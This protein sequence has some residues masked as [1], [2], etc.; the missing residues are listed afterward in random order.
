MFAIRTKIL[1]AM[2]VVAAGTSV[3]AA[4]AASAQAGPPAQFS[5]NYHFADGRLGYSLVSRG[6]PINPGVLVGFN[7]QPDPPGD[8][9]HGALIALL[10]PSS[11]LLFDPN[12]AAS[13]SWSISLVGMADG[14]VMPL[15]VA[16]ENG[17]NT[18]VENMIDGHDVVISLGFGP[19]PIDPTSWASFNPQPDPPGDFLG[20]MFSFATPG[21]PW[22]FFDVFVDGQQLSFDLA[23][24]SGAPEPATWDMLIGGFIGA[25]AVLRLRRRIP[26]LR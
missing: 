5:P 7:P 12:L 16:P 18:S 21:D 17:H 9:D 4:G 2:A 19:G 15:P 1:T 24:P 14:S 6:G 3:L 20:G 8:G 13:W 11:P 22:M 25:G 26:A 23:P 10:N